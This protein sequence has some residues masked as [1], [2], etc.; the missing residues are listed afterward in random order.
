[1]NTVYSKF[2]FTFFTIVF[3]IVSKVIA[4]PGCP[5]VEAGPTVNLNCNTPCTMLTATTA[6][7]TGATTSYAVSSIPYAPPYAYNSGTPILVNT[8][9]YWSAVIP[10]PFNFCFYGNTYNSLVA[11]S[12]GCISFNPVNANAYCAWSYTASCPDPNIISGSTGPFILGPFHDIDP[13]IT[14]TMYYQITGTYPCRT[15]VVSWY[16]VAMFSCTS[17]LATH[18]I[19]LYETTN[20]IEVYMQSKP[21]CSSWNSGNAVVGIQDAAGTTGITAP[22]RNTSQWTATNEAWRFTPNGMSN[23]ALSWYLNGTIISQMDTVTVCPTVSTTYVAHCDYLRCDWTVVTVTDSVLVNVNNGMNFTVTPANPTL[24]AGNSVTLHASSSNPTTTYQ[25][26]NGSVIDSITVS[27]AVTTTYTVTASVVGCTTTSTVTVTVNPNPVIS[28]TGDTVCAGFPATITAN[29]GSTYLWSNSTTVNPMVISPTA[30]TVY[31][32]TGTAANGC[33]GTAIGT[34]TVNANPIVNAGVDQAICT[35]FSANLSASPPGA[36]SYVWDNGAG[37]SQNVTVSPAVTTLY[38]LTV[39]DAN[40]CSGTD[41]VNVAVN[42]GAVVE[43]GNDQTICAGESA[44]LTVTG[45]VS[46]HWNNGV[47]TA[48]NI[49]SPT[50]TT[51]Y[52]VTVSN[53]NGCSGT[54]LVTVNVNQNPVPSITTTGAV[55][56]RN[57]GTASALPA[58]LNYAW[59]NN[60]STQQI[61]NL[62]PGSYSLTVTDANGCT[63]TTSAIV[64]DIHG[65][66]ADFIA[67]PSVLTLF[68][69]PLC[70]FMD[71]S[72]GA[73][74]WLWSFGDGTGSTEHFVTHEYTVVGYYPVTLLV[75]DD[76]GCVDSM[77]IVIEV[78][79][80]YTIYIPNAFTPNGD[81]V[82]DLFGVSGKNIDT[83]DFEMVIFNRW[84]ERVF[85]TNDPNEFWNGTLNNNGGK[86]DGLP[87]AYI[88]KVTAK[89]VNGRVREYFGHVNLIR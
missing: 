9:D 70:V 81:G 87:G 59:S 16:Q 41:A 68:E 48:T 83:K 7:A 42:T 80:L 61:I 39:T 3:L 82:N 22:G 34:A 38:S 26:S 33:T 85:Y 23:Y 18:M 5:D 89:E 6:L 24:C 20:A 71:H 37:N 2:I 88:Y 50:T 15:F 69:N 27:P 13:A 79:D 12:N 21:L 30:T 14:G 1:M 40:G 55:C 32:V 76:Q 73:T 51:V 58:G 53:N 65:P 66:T 63:N 77:Q 67:V 60:E 4:Q 25:W 49:V 19:V 28:I 47:I 10:L 45:G 78:K 46:F 36:A 74:Q 35:G 62:H 17:M 75:T 56:G 11:G 43:A 72:V 84:G 29:G 57:D 54:D 8:D 64:D 52:S 44:T 31:S 86:N